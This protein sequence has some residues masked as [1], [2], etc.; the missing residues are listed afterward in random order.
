MTAI[1]VIMPALIKN[2]RSL[3]WLREAIQSIKRQ[4]FTDWELIIVND[5]SK[6]SWKPIAPMFD[7]NRIYGLKPDHEASSVARARN[8]AA[9]RAQSKLLLPLDA[10]DK[11]LP[12]ALHRFMVAWKS[13]GHKQGIVYS[14]VLMFDNDTS[15]YYRS[16]PYNFNTLLKN[17]Y[18]TVGCLH[19]KS[20]WKRAG[21]W[22]PELDM[23]LE[24]WEYWITLGELGV[25][26]FHLPEPLYEYRRHSNGRIAGLRGAPHKWDMAYQK[27]RSLHINTYNGRRPVGCCGGGASASSKMN[28]AKKASAK[29]LPT[30]MQ[31][32]NAAV[33]NPVKIVYIGRRTGGFGMRGVSGRRYR[34]P[35]K[36]TPFTVQAED[37]IFFGKYN[38]G[39]DFTGVRS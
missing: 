25:C 12:D 19:R 22:K 14:D 15:K 34:V 39:R 23:G 1:S 17:T 28:L 37:A 21:G 10:D 31:M 6:I 26:G 35:G 33:Q 18:M 30:D 24:D 5:H 4:T 3:K 32:A 9:R 38:H 2:E 7:D 8:Q 20:D 16:M 27:L 11:L 29:S 13:H 36:G